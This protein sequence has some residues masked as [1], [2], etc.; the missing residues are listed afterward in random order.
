MMQPSS[1]SFTLIAPNRS[2]LDEFANTLVT[3]GI[4]ASLQSVNGNEQ[5]KFSGQI[6][7]NIADNSAE[8]GELSS[9]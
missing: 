1:L 2:S 6:T 3:Q 7:V 4:A 8:A 9:S 5:G